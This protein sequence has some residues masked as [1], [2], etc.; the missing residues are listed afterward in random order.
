MFAWMA[1]LLAVNWLTVAVVN[2]DPPTNH[3][4]LGYFLGSLF[5]HATLAAGW[6]ALGP[7]RFVWRFPLSI[8]WVVFLPI[9][10][11]INLAVNGGPDGVIFVIGCCLVG[12][13]LAL[14][15]PFWAL[16]LG[17]G[18]Q[19]RHSGDAEKAPARQVQFGIRHLLVVML[20]VGVVLGVGRAV[21]AF[22]DTLFT[23]GG[24]TP[25]FIFLAAAAIVLTLPL[26]LAALMPRMAALGVPLA[27]LFM[28]VMTLVELPLLDRLGGGG[29]ELGHFIAI[30]VAM[31]AVIL[32]SAL[33]VRLNGYCL[34]T[35]GRRIQAWQSAPP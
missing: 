14:Q 15:F 34:Y 12:Q 7:G 16:A 26:L 3:V 21:F 23:G 19:L 29:P 25:A 4:L 27:L 10:G 1:P 24:E 22:N 6:A 5:A 13:W 8:V 33:V 20:L 31:A 11:G 32:L 2:F 17:L 30:N 35:Q 9:A 18:L 28:G